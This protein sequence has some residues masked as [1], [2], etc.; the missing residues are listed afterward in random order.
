[1]HYIKKIASAAEC[2]FFN[3]KSSACVFLV[4]YPK[5]YVHHE[6]IGLWYYKE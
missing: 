1:M 4:T 3:K 2:E 6:Q 5:V